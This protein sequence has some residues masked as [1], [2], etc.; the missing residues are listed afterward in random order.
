MIRTLGNYLGLLRRAGA[1]ETWAVLRHNASERF[2]ERRLGIAT[3]GTVGMHELGIDKPGHGE[4]G[5][6]PFRDF[7]TMFSLVPIDAG[8]DVLIDYGSGKGRALILAAAY[9][10]RRI[11]GVEFSPELNRVAVHNLEAARGRLRCRDVSTVVADAGAYAVPPDVTVAYFNNP[12]DRVL[13]EATLA[14]LH[15]S[16]TAHPRRLRIV[17]SYPPDSQL[18]AAIAACEWLT[19]EHHLALTA[20]RRCLIAI[21]PPV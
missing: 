5:P 15:A 6:T 10:F 17:L 19:V 8:R 21:S 1:R 7:H 13:F 14:Q 20:D 9:P 2:H 11:I 3:V 16:V 18:P 12:F 4:Y